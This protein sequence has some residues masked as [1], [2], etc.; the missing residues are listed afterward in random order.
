MLFRKAREADLSAVAQIYDRIH[1]AEEQGLVSPGWVRSIYP[2]PA[3]ASDA[4]N[5]GDLFVAEEAGTVVGTAIINQIQP[6]AYNNGQWAYPATDA[7][8]MVLHTLVIDPF[9]A[10]KGYGRRFVCFYEDYALSLGC[11]FLRM[12]T[13]IRNAP[14]R[15]LYRRLGFQERNTVEGTFCGIEGVH[16]LLLEKRLEPGYPRG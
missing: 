12:D 10:G 9:H 11:A 4:L 13:Q 15:A 3:T 6:E 7:E 5:R 2:T 1:T 14:A 8:I 16:L